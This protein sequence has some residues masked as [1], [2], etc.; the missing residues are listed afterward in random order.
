M[1][2]FERQINLSGF[3]PKAQQQLQKAKVLVIG[4]GGLG[5]PVLLYLDAAGVGT[6]AICDGDVVA[7][8]NLN[9]QVIFSESDITK[10]KAEVAGIYLKQKYSDINIEIINKF[11]T[12]ENT[13]QI[14]NAYDLIIDGSD[15]FQTRY[16]VNDA[17]VLLNK[18]LVF[19]AVYQN[20][21]QV[22][23]FNVSDD[24]AVS[25]N[26]RDV[27]PNPPSEN[28][29]LNCNETGVLGV[30]PGIIGVMMASEAIKLITGFGKALINKMLYYN[31]LT[32]TTYET[33]IAPNAVAKSIIPKTPED[34]YKTDYTLLCGNLPSI[35]WSEA[36]LLKN[37]TPG[38]VI[39]LDVRETHEQ[40][41]LDGIETMN[42][43]LQSLSENIEPLN[44]AENILVFCQ[45]GIRSRKAVA[46]LRSKFL[47]KNIY[48]VA[49][50]IS[51]LNST[52]NA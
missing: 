48:S 27:F 11:L 1:S 42:I 9:R 18:P 28:E 46:V 2:R 7:A 5:C 8:S 45:S 41:K 20:E 14:F 35:E 37:N 34:F 51:K 22:A 36:L 29:I 10:S 30:L 31:L 12:V 24:N 19:G 49:G 39:L 40:P 23:V 38:K 52:I 15:N 26:Y 44:T 21:G 33:E 13:L 4:A 16:M 50:G 3:G 25:S 47:Q 32:N 6:L 43:P 17:C